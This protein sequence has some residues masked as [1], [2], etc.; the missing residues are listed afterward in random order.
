[1]TTAIESVENRLDHVERVLSETAVAQAEAIAASNERLSRI[2]ANAAA[3]DERLS[4]IE[5]TVAANAAASDERLSRIEATVAANAATISANAA[6]IAASDERLSRI[7]ATVA[8][9]AAAIAASDERLSRIEATVAA[10]AAAIAA[11]D[12]RLSRI[13]ATV[14]AN[15]TTIAAA[16][17]AQDRRIAHLTEQQQRNNQDL[18]VIKGWQTEAVV[19]RNAQEI[20]ARLAPNGILMRIFP[21]SEIAFYLSSA[22]RHN[23]MTKA[24]VDNAGAIDFLMDGTDHTGAPISFAIEVSYT[25]GNDDIQRALE[26]APLIAK[27]LGREAVLPAVAAEVISEGFEENART[28]HVS[29][30]YVPNGN[31]IME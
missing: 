13:E 25:A 18:S 2:E 31:R 28:Y 4:R 6:A 15:A 27:L 3:S 21:K 26:R 24:E 20:F 12:E 29:W 5:A 16:S 30:A 10:N 7:E 19:A 11:S 17:E 23:F 1:M 9:N 14:A 22:T 8:A